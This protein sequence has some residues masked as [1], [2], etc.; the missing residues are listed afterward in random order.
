MKYHF[1]AG[2]ITYSHKWVEANSLEEAIEKAN[3]EED[4]EWDGNG[5]EMCRVYGELLADNDETIDEFDNLEPYGNEGIRI[6]GNKS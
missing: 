3:T 1:E 4:W 5:S 2:F 6:V